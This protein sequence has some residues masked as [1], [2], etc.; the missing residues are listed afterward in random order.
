MPV[1]SGTC[2]RS[3]RRA[4]SPPA[5]ARPPQHRQCS[6]NTPWRRAK[7]AHHGD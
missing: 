5:T 3:R 1:P 6:S 2:S 7:L 4:P